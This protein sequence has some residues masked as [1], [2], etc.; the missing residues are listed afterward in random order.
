M[1]ILRDIL[2]EAYLTNFDLFP[3][4]ARRRFWLVTQRSSPTNPTPL[5]EERCVTRQKWVDGRLPI[6][7]DF[8]FPRILGHSPFSEPMVKLL[9]S[10]I[11]QLLIRGAIQ[12]SCCYFQL[13]DHKVIKRNHI[14]KHKLLST[15]FDCVFEW[16]ITARY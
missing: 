2:S 14:G 7:Q 8:N 6:F 11:F 16:P 12:L 5:G 10:L 9:V 4:L 13:D 1:F 3:S 15:S